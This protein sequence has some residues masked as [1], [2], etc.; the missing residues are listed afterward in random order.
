MR[1]RSSQLQTYSLYSW[2]NWA[3]WEPALV[4][5][6]TG[7][8]GDYVC[9]LIFLSRGFLQK[10]N[11]SLIKTSSCGRRLQTL[12]R[13]ASKHCCRKRSTRANFHR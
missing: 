13:A 9:W 2:R 5:A 6:L 4:G 3:L 12:S 10:Q 1:M 7:T 11:S 8:M